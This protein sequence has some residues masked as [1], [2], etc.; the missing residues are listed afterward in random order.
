MGTGDVGRKGVL[1]SPNRNGRH[2][3]R[4]GQSVIMTALSLITRRAIDE[5]Y[6]AALCRSR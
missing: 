6:V 3:T 5:Y 1:A 2:V 4:P